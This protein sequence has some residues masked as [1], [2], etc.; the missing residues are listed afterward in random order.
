M[1]FDRQANVVLQ[2][3]TPTV[4]VYSYAYL[5]LLMGLAAMS[6]GLGLLIEHAS[7]AHL[8]AGPS[9]AY[10]GG[11]VVFLLSLVAT[12]MVT[13]TGA[14]R[15]GIS[16]KLGASAAILGVLATQRLIPPVALAAALVL[17]LAA[18]VFVEQ[19]VVAPSQAPRRR[20]LSVQRESAHRPVISGL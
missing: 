16:L 14:R 11:A 17:V 9:I 19:T 18:L 13:V 2:A 5:P 6:A 7:D 8:G 20:G 4:V 12:R 3:G 10:L 1:Y 15:L